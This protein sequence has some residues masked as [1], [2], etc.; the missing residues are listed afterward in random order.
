MAS[1]LYPHPYVEFPLLFTSARTEAK[2][3]V[4]EQDLRALL[5]RLGPR[6]LIQLAHSTPCLRSIALFI[7]DETFGGERI[8]DHFYIMTCTL[9]I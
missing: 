5:R 7:A 1:F 8:R 4:L 2:P 9:P 6:P 3:D